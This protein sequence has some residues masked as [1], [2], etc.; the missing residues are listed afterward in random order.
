MRETSFIKQNKEKWAEMESILPQGKK[1]PDKLS[2]LFV[3]V[4]NDLS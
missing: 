2:E 4:T 3:Q 1:N